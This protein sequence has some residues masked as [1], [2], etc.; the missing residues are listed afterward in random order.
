MENNLLRG[1]NEA[2]VFALQL[3]E[4]LKT[5]SDK[6]AQKKEQSKTGGTFGTQV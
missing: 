6:L 2:F 5:L 4:T 3:I 1:P